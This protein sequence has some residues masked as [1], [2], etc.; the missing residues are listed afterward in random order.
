ML[1][2][3]KLPGQ[4]LDWSSALSFACARGEH[5]AVHFAA[6][7]VKA[8]FAIRANAWHYPEMI[9]YSKRTMKTLTNHHRREFAVRSSMFQEGTKYKEP[10]TLE[11]IAIASRIN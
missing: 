7:E 11:A 1:F 4:V 5:D 8:H 6:H 10:V 9:M 2:A 3:E